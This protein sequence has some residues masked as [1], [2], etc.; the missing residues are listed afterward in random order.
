[1]SL[2]LLAASCHA[3]DRAA[4]LEGIATALRQSTVRVVSGATRSSGVIVSASGRVMTVAHAV[5]KADRPVRVLLHDGTTINAAIVLTD[6][7]RDVAILQLK[8]AGKTISDPVLIM[9]NRTVEIGATVLGCGFPGREADA[10]AGVV[11]IGG[12]DAVTSAS[13][14]STCTLTAGDS[15]G[16]LVN[17]AGEL[18]GLHRRIGAASSQNLHIPVAV[19]LAAAG[20]ELPLTATAGTPS[21]DFA[22][23]GFQR[24]AAAEQ[25]LE[26]YSA[27]L[28]FRDTWSGEAHQDR[29]VAA[30]RLTHDLLAAKASLTADLQKTDVTFAADG[31]DIPPTRAASLL[32]SDRELDLAVW[33][34]E[35]PDAAF[36]PAAARDESPAPLFTLV[37]GGRSVQPGIVGRI[38]HAEPALPL[39]LGCVFDAPAGH[40]LCVNE[41][42]PN[43]AASDA[44]MRRSDILERIGVDSVRDFGELESQ[45]SQFQPGDWVRLTYSRAGDVVSRSV[46]LRHD[47]AEQLARQEYLDGRSGELSL[48]RSGFRGVIQHDLPLLPDDCG[49]PLVDS[50]GHLIGINIA[51][52]SREA[53]LAIPIEAV[54]KRMA[55]EQPPVK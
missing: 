20:S 49:G 31:H 47:P 46:Q 41:I 34:L 32:F 15:G 33:R 42:L 7:E 52:R 6:A 9:R 5:P 38:R 35:E 55:E 29:R 18:I 44:Q 54:W 27:T 26:R 36:T 30:T 13:L 45:L 40:G 11:R 21:P 37:F 3:S 53:T 22:D 28:V 16:P 24:S 43:S 8:L 25:S 17:L 50:D 10:T 19:C 12:I 2:S 1:M 51:R 48:R 23:D 4:S 39:Q 14:R